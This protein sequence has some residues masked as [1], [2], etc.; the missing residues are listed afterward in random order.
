MKCEIRYKRGTQVQTLTLSG[1]EERSHFR[2]EAAAMT[3]ALAREE[4]GALCLM[5]TPHEPVELVSVK[6]ELP[7]R[8]H[9]KDALFLNGYQSWT[10]SE[11]LGVNSIMPGLYKTP[12]LGQKLFHL[13]S[14]G[15]YDFERYSLVPGELHGFTYA[16]VR[17]G[18]EYHLFGSLSERAGF[19][20]IRFFAHENRI[21]LAR[22]CAGR[23]ITKP[24]AALEVAQLTGAED[25][26]FDLWF[27]LQ[28]VAP[29]TA[30]PIRGYTSWYNY[31]QDISEEKILKNLEAVANAPVQFD[32]FQIDDGFQTH[33]GD[34]LSIDRK[35]FPNGLKCIADRVRELGMIPGL[36]LNPFG[37]EFKSEMAAQ[38][39]DW[40]LRGDDGKPIVAGCNWGGF[41]VWDFYNPE[42]REYV[43]KCLQTAVQDWG[44]GLLKLDFLYA[45]CMKPTA[46]RTRGQ[47]M[48]EAM[49]FIREATE[50]AL[51]LG[52]GVPLGAAFGKVDYCRIGCDVGLDYDDKPHMRVIH[53]ERVSTKNSMRNTLF[54]R[55]L[56]GRAFWNDPDVFLLR[57]ENISLTWEQRVTLA[58]I[59]SLFGG[60]KFTSDDVSG[61]SGEQKKV[62]QAVLN[63]KNPKDVRVRLMGHG[64]QITADGE[65][66]SL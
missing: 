36:W 13:R 56:N 34:W 48:C 42:A 20:A 1:T 64:Y 35:K 33:V 14:Y 6:V 22:D 17:R 61:Y 47:I 9:K 28:N 19:T 23:V 5:L 59:N 8:F 52:C 43:R 44:F 65:E 53:R 60:V 21:E 40:L 18:G 32:V 66:L 16:Y 39:P 27:A 31:Y 30:K 49:D 62:L 26:V 54:R 58:R 41:W 25:E 57:E 55:G 63:A 38:H 51:V 46:E 3:A 2:M 12:R 15:D 24:F 50:G 4:N 37:C 7:F 11:E 10:D 45:V 29:P